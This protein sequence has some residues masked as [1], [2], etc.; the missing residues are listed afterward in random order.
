MEYLYEVQADAIHN[1]RPVKLNAIVFSPVN[2]VEKPETAKADVL[3]TLRKEYDITGL[4]GIKITRLIQ[5][6]DRKSYITHL[7]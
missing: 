5:R 4:K 7:Q 6:P 3:A 2:N 1:G